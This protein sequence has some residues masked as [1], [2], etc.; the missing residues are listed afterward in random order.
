MSFTAGSEL[1]KYNLPGVPKHKHQQDW[2]NFIAAYP[3]SGSASKGFVYSGD[4]RKTDTT[5]T[6][7]DEVS[8]IQP[9]IVTYIW[10]R[11]S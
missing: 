4:Y 3:G 2:P 9:S 5:E 6:G 1:G 7:E 11:V 8:I 10:R